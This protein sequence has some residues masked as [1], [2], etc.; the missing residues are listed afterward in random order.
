MIRTICTL[1][2]NFIMGYSIQNGTD[3]FTFIE[4]NNIYSNVELCIYNDMIIILT[5]VFI[6]LCLSC[7]KD[8]R[9]RV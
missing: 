3:L 6:T 5:I 2:T 1:I 9:E 4:W 8:F 7:I